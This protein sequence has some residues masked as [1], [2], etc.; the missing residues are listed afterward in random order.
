MAL[1]IAKDLNS[2]ASQINIKATT[3][4]GMGFPGR[5]EGIEAHAVVIVV[6]AR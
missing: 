5:K 2:G 3:T 1:Y 6:S 4:E